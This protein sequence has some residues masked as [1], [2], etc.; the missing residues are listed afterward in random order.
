MRIQIQCRNKDCETT[1][2]L[3]RISG[4]NNFYQGKCPTCGY[5]MEACTLK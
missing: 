4:T 5:H 3:E 1:N 2:V